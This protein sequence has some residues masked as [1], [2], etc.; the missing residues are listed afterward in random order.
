MTTAVSTGCSSRDLATGDATFDGVIVANQPPL[1]DIDEHAAR[2]EMNRSRLIRGNLATRRLPSLLNVL[3]GTFESIAREG[4]ET[5]VKVARTR[6]LFGFLT[7]GF[8]GYR[9]AIDR[10]SAVDKPISH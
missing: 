4:M 2:L 7:D 5:K 10:V 1:A 9:V 6:S 3:L 8:G